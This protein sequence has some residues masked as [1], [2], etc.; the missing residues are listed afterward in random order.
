[1]PNKLYGEE[2]GAALILS[3]EA[4]DGL[5]LRELITEL[6][7][8]LKAEKLAQM[9]HPSKWKIVQDDEIPK[10]PSKKYKRIGLS[11]VLG[12]DPVEESCPMKATT[13]V[14]AKVDIAVISGF[15]FFLACYV[16]F[17]H[18][19]ADSSWGAFSTLRQFPWHVHV[20]FTLGGYS[21]ALPMAPPVKKKF[22]YFIARMMAMYPLYLLAL[23]FAVGNLLVSCRPSTFRSTFHW[24][25]QIDDLYSFP[26]GENRT[27][28]L[29]PLFCEGTPAIRGSWAANFVLTIIT[30]ILGLQATPA[31]AFCWFVGFYLWFSSMYYQCLALFPSL[32]NWIYSRRGKGPALLAV[33]AVLVC[34]NTALLLGFWYGVKDANGYSHFD[35]TTGKIGVSAK[36]DGDLTYTGLFENGRL[37]NQEEAEVNN[38]TV[39][40]FYLFAPFWY[41][42]FI[43]GICAAFLY[44]AYRPAESHNRLMWGRIADLISLTILG[45][46]IAHIAQGKRP[47]GGGIDDMNRPQYLS[48]DG[49]YMR[50]DEADTYLD[51]LAVA[52]LWD[53]M[54]ARLFFPLTTLWIFALSTGEGVTAMFF[55]NRFLV[56]TLSPTAYLCFLFHQMVAQWYFAAT[57]G[58]WWDWWRFRKTQ[59]WFSPNPCPVEWYEYFYV[60][61]LVVMWSKLMAKIEPTLT[62]MFYRAK[63][64]ISGGA[65]EPDEMDTIDV[66]MDIVEGEQT[67]AQASS[68][69]PSPI[70]PSL[71]APRRFGS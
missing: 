70:P 71:L 32:Y 59:Y 30:H 25:S 58:M 22:G 37:I 1:M 52:R 3:P 11:T 29:T 43:G 49:F 51:N 12:L 47:H 50:P 40:G 24:D 34:F 56:E 38:A 53:N 60:V 14:K 8:L 9:K 63:L 5:E 35:S 66:I 42:Y 16:M 55:R 39:L 7:A 48:L 57:R 41:T 64:W 10:T 13:T 17:M 27:E 46:S 45:I 36:A 21:M 44:D 26:D 33:M 68:W 15:R 54:Y 67:L 4:P 19:G 69:C 61:A 62:D 23:V 18:I 20:F 65:P 2:V 6:R 31:W 28:T